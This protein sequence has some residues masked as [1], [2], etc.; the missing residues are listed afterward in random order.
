MNEREKAFYKKIEELDVYNNETFDFEESN[1]L[2]K[3]IHFNGLQFNSCIFNC[4]SISFKYI[5]D[6]TISIVFNNCTF[7]C[8]LSFENCSLEKLLFNDTLSIKS[9]NINPKYDQNGTFETFKFSN[10]PNSNKVELHTDFSISNI[11]VKKFFLFEHINH[12]SGKLHF[13][14]NNFG[15]EKNEYGNTI[16][17]D[18]TISNIFFK[19]N[20]FNNLTTFL[21]ST[22]KYNQHELKSTSQVYK[23][24]R[25]FDNTFEKVKFDNSSFIG[26]CEFDKCDFLS[27]TWFEWCENLTNSHLKFIACEFK[28]FSLFNNSKINF[29]NIDRCTFNKSSSF[30]DSEFN[31]IK[32][33]EVKFGGGAY[34]DE[35][36]INK[37]LDKS[38]LKNKNKILEWKRTLRA[39]K[40]ELQKTD[41]KIDFNIYRNYELAAHYEELNV[42]TNFK[43][44]SIL[45]ATKWSS[46]FG[47]WFWAFWFTLIVGF[48]FF[49]SFYIFE[50]INQ[51]VNLNNWPDFIYGYFR[52][53]LITDFKNE[54][55]EAGESVLKF[56]CFMSLFPFII[57][58]IA[59]AFG[60]YEM[61]QSFR[62]FKA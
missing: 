2:I 54:Y 12:V 43:D 40:Q 9:L 22:I 38:Y 27:T 58:K 41:N 56:N 23:N 48:V 5:Q 61:I 30:T 15:I 57:G 24:N 37:V 3:K 34:F 45:W 31:K 6:Q 14:N 28:G 21:N 11:T 26:K 46:N 42:S 44:T 47:N 17:N 52:F 39:I 51:T 8:G 55:Y 16:F 29:L 60:L 35:M 62:K 1:L 13:Y 49:S 18:S 7:N 20:T 53:F 10:F 25:F 19:R 50:N 33:Y 36:K 59:V 4:N 32:L